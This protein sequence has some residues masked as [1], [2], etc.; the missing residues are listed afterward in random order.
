M[1]FVVA[2]CY[3]LFFTT[4]NFMG[5]NYDPVA[6]GHQ[7]AANVYGLFGLVSNEVKQNEGESADAQPHHHS[8]A[9]KIAR[10]YAITVDLSAILGGK[11]EIS[12]SSF[13]HSAGVQTNV[14]SHT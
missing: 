10:P 14:G 7:A 4:M 13:V 9:Y 3:G 5:P 6:S 2:I 1:T 12:L 11:A 8:I